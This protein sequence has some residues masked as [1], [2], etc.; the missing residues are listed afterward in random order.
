MKVVKAEDVPTQEMEVKDEQAAPVDQAKVEELKEKFDLMQK[1]LTD[2]LYDIKL[3][4]EETSFLFDV[5]YDNIPWKGYESYAISETHTQLKELIKNGELNGGAKVEI[6]EAIFHFIKSY[7]SK[8]VENAKLF[9]GIADQFALPVQEINTDRQEM[10]DISLELV[11][12]EQGIP[13]EQLVQQLNA[14]QQQG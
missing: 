1:Q 6:I 13:V 2:K 14:E 12:V 7:E 11:S 3:S 4:K 9:R 5:V 8:G 10:R